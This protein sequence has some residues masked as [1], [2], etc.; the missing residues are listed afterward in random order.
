MDDQTDR[1]QW[2]H[3]TAGLELAGVV[4]GMIGLGYLVDQWL[5]SRPWGILTG[6]FIGIVG[7]LYKTA[8]DAI[9]TM[10]RQGKSD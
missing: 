3:A 4:I 7:G 2:K 10:N 8:R 6:A 1:S 5:D 9:R